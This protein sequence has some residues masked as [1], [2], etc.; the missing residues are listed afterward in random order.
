MALRSEG[1]SQAD[2]AKKAGFSYA[3]AQRMEKNPIYQAKGA[4]SKLIKATE[5][6]GE[7][8]DYDDLCDEAKRA[9]EDFTYFQERYLGRIGLPWQKDAA[10]KLEY[11]LET[12]NEEYVVVNAPP[13]SG[14]ST[15][16]VH[17][18][19]LW[20]IVRNRNIR[21]M[22]GSATFS[23]AKKYVRRLRRTL[24]SVEPLRANVNEL[25]R[26]EA[27]DAVASLAVD[28]G[29]F[30]PVD[31]DLWTGDT[32]VVAK[33]GSDNTVSE[34]EATVTAYGIDSS[35][36]G[37]RVDGAFW[38]D[39]VDPRKTRTSDQKDAL[40]EVFQDVV[41]TRLEPGGL[42][43]L[44]GQRLDSTDLYRF[45]L[46]LNAPYEPDDDND[47]EMAEVTPLFGESREGKKYHHLVYRAHYEENCNS[48][49]KKSSPPW[50]EGCLLSPRRLHWGK[51]SSVES[52]SGER[53]RVLYQQEDVD[54]SEVL[55]PNAWV[56]GGDEFVGCIDKDRNRLEIP[57]GLDPGSCI[58]IATADPSPT[59]YW[60]VQWW[61]YDPN[62]ERRYLIDLLRKKMDAPDF[63]DWDATQHRFVGV[64]DEW[65]DAS[66]T[67]G[68]PITTWIVEANAAQRFMLQYD[69][70]RRWRS[71]NSVDILPHTTSRNKSDPQYGVETI[72]PHWRFGRVRLP[73]FGDG[74][75]ISMRLIDEVTKYPHGRTDDCVMAEW[76]FEWNLPNLSIPI[77]PT[78][79]AWR[80]SWIG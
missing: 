27:M 64:M 35:F 20:M 69:H 53:Y 74:K 23:S 77:A 67:L 60:S 40:Q 39:L 16:F 8:K 28:F 79:S 48:L 66:R 75:V 56:F 52:N 45:A 6:I 31:R 71:L 18:I 33:S 24:E 57:A 3:T 17:D 7:P 21:I 55:V 37:Q 54:P 1:W 49:H 26:G 29:R 36:I 19:P 44:Q 58:S 38:D 34:K 68:F 63:L 50:P 80:P 76:F 47:E 13:G 25:R 5:S 51:L 65:Q 10:E 78:H 73:G 42:L 70:V 41:E 12:E 72:A 59:N 15:I 43:V 14:K 11:L 62:S 4:E 46:D 9:L 30:R 32:F 22:I 61:I 2:A